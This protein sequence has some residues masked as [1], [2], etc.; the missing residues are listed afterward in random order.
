M[1][2]QSVRRALARAM[3]SGADRL[4]LD[5]QRD[6]LTGLSSR[7]ALMA[8]LDRAIA[9]E[10]PVT[11]LYVDLDD[12]K[13]IND[14]LGHGVG[15]ELLSHVAAAMATVPGPVE[16]LAR[17]GGDEFVLLAI[18]VAQPRA[19]A[20]ALRAAITHP[21]SLRGLEI[22]VGASIG[23]ACWPEDGRDAAGLLEAADAAMYEAKGSG[24]NQIGRGASSVHRNREAQRAALE[25]TTTLPEA[26]RRDELLL[27]WQ[28]IV[29]VTDLSIVGLEALVR[30]QHPQR[31]LLYP[32]AFLPFA[33]QTGMVSAVDEWVATAVTRQRVVWQSQ[34]LDPYVGFNLAPQFAR[35]PGALE[36]LMSRLTEGG[37]SVDHVTVEL[38]ESEA[39]REDQRL[40]TF[41]HGL[42]DA[43]VT[44]SLDDFGRAYSSLDR[45]R[46]VPARWIKLDR[47][48]MARVPE[49][50]AATEVAL[51]I[52]D[53]LRA[54]KLEVIVEGV[55]REEQRAVLDA[56]GTRVAQ[57]YLLGRPAPADE[58][59]ERLRVSGPSRLRELRAA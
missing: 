46:D 37:L 48:F 27:H 12:F 45:L 58:L 44:V 26:I 17:Q 55:E 32:G 10:R 24:R 4:D 54:L 16:M 35:R 1:S 50:P 38:T 47:A 36:G 31:G 22:S 39:L 3:R 59:Y 52:V 8:H 13:L 41:L 9:R 29:D 18:D 2:I 5:A 30:W 11:L 15:D 21:V 51:A 56:H 57:G 33:E 23:I 40:L 25:F 20:R 14:T 42:H 53:L 49:D 7:A 43:G 6:H 28:P 19:L 34:G